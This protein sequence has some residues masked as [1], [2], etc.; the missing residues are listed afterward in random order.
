MKLTLFLDD[1]DGPELLRSALETE[2]NY[3][4]S[5]KADVPHAREKCVDLA[6]MIRQ[7]DIAVDGREEKKRCA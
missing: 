2:L 3:W 4:R 1:E 7:L 6:N 5:V